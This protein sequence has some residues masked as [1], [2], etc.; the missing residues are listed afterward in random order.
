MNYGGKHPDYDTY[1]MH[2][3]NLD[4]VYPNNSVKVTQN[5]VTA[6]LPT[7]K[8]MKKTEKKRKL[9]NS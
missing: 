7:I 1:S 8:A 4:F 2:S 3:S 5:T 9:A 6:G